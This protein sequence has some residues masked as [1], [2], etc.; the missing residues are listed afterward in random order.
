MVSV[1]ADTTDNILNFYKVILVIRYKIVNALAL[2]NSKN[3]T[4][5]KYS[6]GNYLSVSINVVIFIEKY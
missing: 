2:K 4:L 5:F 3:Q 6:M 1:F